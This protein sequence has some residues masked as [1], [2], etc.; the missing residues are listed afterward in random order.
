MTTAAISKKQIIKDRLVRQGFLPIYVHDQ[1]DS[2]AQIEGAIE[3]GCTVLE[4][5]C[6][7]HDAREMIPWIRKHYPDIAVVGAT[8]IDSPR[9]AGFLSRNR[10]NFMTVDEMMDL[11]VDGLVSFLRFRPETYAKAA[12]RLIMIPGV[13]TYNEAI[14]QLELGAD[15]IKLPGVN[16]QGTRIVKAAHSPMHGAMPAMVSGGITL[17]AAREYIEAGAI[18]VSAGFDLTLKD[19]APATLTKA[20]VAQRMREYLDTVIDARRQHQPALHDAVRSG[21]DNPL[22]V[23]GVLC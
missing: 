14:D 21:V 7:R 15:F 17:Q 5:T 10:P 16:P 1:Y 23:T 11:G 3:A 20:M 19:L 2:K 8:M 22:K 9:V 13:S 12:G 4:Y 6:R 18:L